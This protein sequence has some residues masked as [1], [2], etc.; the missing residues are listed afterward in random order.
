MGEL[1]V[2][3]ILWIWFKLKKKFLSVPW[4]ADNTPPFHR[5]SNVQITCLYWQ[6]CVS[7]TL[8]WP[9][10][11]YFD[12]ICFATVSFPGIVRLVG[13]LFLSVFACLCV[14]MN[15]IGTISCLAGRCTDRHREREIDIE[16]FDKLTGFK[17]CDGNVCHVQH[18]FIASC[19]NIQI[20]DFPIVKNNQF[21]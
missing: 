10:L 20:V 9:E 3:L 7:Y 2:F 14:C 13:R 11:A 18:D 5:P 6:N 17:E 21:Q 8:A 19:T 15:C 16:R 1:N 12:F 4:H